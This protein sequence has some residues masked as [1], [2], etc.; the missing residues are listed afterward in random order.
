MNDMQETQS[1]QQLLQSLLTLAGQL[2]T[3][4][5]V[6]AFNPGLGILNGAM[7]KSEYMSQ[8][9]SNIASPIFGPQVGAL[10]G[11][12]IGSLYQNEGS[13]LP[14]LS[15]QYVN[16]LGMSSAGFALQKDR[17]NALNSYAKGI[18][19]K[20]RNA[21]TGTV[22]PG[23]VGPWRTIFKL[24]PNDAGMAA[25]NIGATAR[26]LAD[27]IALDKNSGFDL[28]S[29]NSQ[30]L[31]GVTAAVALAS[32][33]IHGNYAG[34]SGVQV[35]QVAK[36]LAG[37][38]L[39]GAQNITD[40]VAEIKQKFLIDAN[41]SDQQIKQYMKSG[42]LATK[43]AAYLSDM[44]KAIEPLKDIF[45]K[46]IAA[47]YSNLEQLTGI[48]INGM[49]PQGIANT[50]S[51]IRNALTV[52]G[53]TV[54]DIKR[55]QDGLAAINK[56]YGIHVRPVDQLRQATQLTHMIHKLES[57]G[58]MTDAQMRNQLALLTA[59]T[60]GSQFADNYS[61]A[62]GM[63]AAKNA[64]T[65]KTQEERL[66]EF[67][68]E[69][70]RLRTEQGLSAD[71]A[72]NKLADVGSVSALRNTMYTHQAKAHASKAA[73]EQH[74]T[75][76]TN[77]AVN[78]QLL[79]MSDSDRD[80]LAETRKKLNDSGVNQ[81]ILIGQIFQAHGNTDKLTGIMQR[82]GLD[83][84]AMDFYMRVAQSRTADGRNIGAMNHGY[85]NYARNKQRQ[86]YVQAQVNEIGGLAENALY[87]T[88]RNNKLTDQVREVFSD[89]LGESELDIDETNKP[90]KNEL[91]GIKLTKLH[92]QGVLFNSL[93]QEQQKRI[94][95]YAQ[96]HGVSISEATKH[97]LGL[98]SEIDLKKLNLS[99]AAEK[100][101]TGQLDL[102]TI[103]KDGL[104]QKQLNTAD[105]AR[106]KVAKIQKLNKVSDHISQ[107]NSEDQNTVKELIAAQRDA[108]AKGEDFDAANW[109]KNKKYDN[110]DATDIAKYN[111]AKA[112]QG[113]GTS[114]TQDVKN[115]L[116]TLVN[117]YKHFVK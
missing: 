103:S 56:Q 105:K 23:A 92:G 44:T 116:A 60:A 114:M 88:L 91:G 75:Q 82:Y 8:V 22:E 7:P 6:S 85:T 99:D 20:A 110:F 106:R 18:K 93:A 112:A 25:D 52:T 74:I 108:I 37:R 83:Q 101:L 36:Q 41:T 115:I 51:G 53:A 68:K 61:K 24:D 84:T 109:V 46:D 13:R 49:S 45:G 14:I 77:S 50:A 80:A 97:Q 90:K 33:D 3:S 79:S 58:F 34:F 57:S 42:T 48:N 17:L 87:D 29:E 95:A 4:A 31:Q 10:L 100:I 98:D 15:Q 55:Y 71:Q 1:A 89:Q 104:D 81:N 117:I 59:G 62:Y 107:F 38:G 72:F 70:D 63:W 69:F 30:I 9:I 19:Q 43:T 67:Q 113:I 21:L 96:S 102:S 111:A 86:Q 76:Q 5:D 26:I 40:A 94:L 65:Y 78:L 32:K 64:G 28:Q 66:T 39:L 2:Q 73:M 27:N 12:T 47:I 35:S 11:N 16:R 54:H